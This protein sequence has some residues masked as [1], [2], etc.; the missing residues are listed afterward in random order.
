V[1]PQGHGQRLA[2]IPSPI[3]RANELL[4]DTTDTDAAKRASAIA[5]LVEQQ[6]S[7]VT[8]AVQNALID[9]DKHV[10]IEALHSAL[11]AQ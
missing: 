6:G 3:G 4:Q 9:P 11:L 10:R 1:Y 2:P 8:E 5:N 7:A